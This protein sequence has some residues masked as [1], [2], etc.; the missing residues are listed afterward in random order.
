MTT[1]KPIS[2][3]ARRG[4]DAPTSDLFF[5]LDHRQFDRGALKPGAL[6]HLHYDPLRMPLDGDYCHGTSDQPIVAHLD[7]ADGAPIREIPLVSKVGLV[8]TPDVDPTGQGSML[9]GSFEIPASAK[10]LVLWFTYV[11]GSGHLH[12]DSANGANYQFRFSQDDLRLLRASVTNDPQAP[13]SFFTLAVAAGADI[14]AVA[15][16]ARA[17]IK[18][19]PGTP[20]IV[21]LQRTGETEADGRIV[22]AASNHAVA[23]GASVLFDLVY[24]ADDRSFTEDNDDHHFIATPT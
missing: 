11:C 12:Y 13:Q 9:E 22:W 5:T 19:V 15:A 2:L 23:H 7:F 10:K 8:S 18:G 24:T 16:T 21:P 20:K 3:L 6:C 17:M 14:T 4:V 1:L